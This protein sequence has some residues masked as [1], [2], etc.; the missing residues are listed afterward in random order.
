VRV[1]FVAF[2]AKSRN[3]RMTLVH[4]MKIDEC[5]E[6]SEDDNVTAVPVTA[7][8]QTTNAEFTTDKVAVFTCNVAF[9]NGP[10]EYNSPP[11]DMFP[12][13]AVRKILT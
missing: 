5:K 4:E 6:M 10:W 13:V 3:P 1:A 7:P 2:V 9:A 12:V 11:A 8:K